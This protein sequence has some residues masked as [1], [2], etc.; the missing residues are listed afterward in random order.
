MIAHMVVGVYQLIAEYELGEI[1][2]YVLWML[3][4]AMHDNFQMQLK[5]I[6]EKLCDKIVIKISEGFQVSHDVFADILLYS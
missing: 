3:Q 2:P 4:Q 1:Q 5:Y 6:Q